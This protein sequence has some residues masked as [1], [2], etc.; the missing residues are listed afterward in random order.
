MDFIFDRSLVLYLPL[1]QLDGASIMSQDAYG[2]VCTVTGATWGGQGRAFDGADDIINCGRNAILD[3]TGPF[4]IL[5]WLKTTVTTIMIPV[6]KYRSNGGYSLT[7]FTG[8]VIRNSVQNV[9]T[10][11]NLDDDVSIA[12]GTWHHA[13]ISF[14]GSKQYIYR[15]GVLSKS[16]DCAV[17]PTIGNCDF[18]IGKRWE[19][20]DYLY[21]GQVGEVRV[22]RRA[23]TALEF[24]ND[25]LAT[26]WRYR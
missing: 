13:A 16:A 19:L 21:N 12:D 26:K 10:S 20:G 7:L 23:L 3:I 18:L 24:L 25:F 2:H 14:D 1:H 6:D 11:S 8:G 5:A 17:T 22:Y 9:T 4:T 15:E